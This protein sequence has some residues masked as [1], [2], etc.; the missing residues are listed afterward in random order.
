MTTRNTILCWVQILPMSH[1]WEA[2]MKS[3]SSIALKLKEKIIV[4]REQMPFFLT[5]Y[6]GQV[7]HTTNE[8]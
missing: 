5:K 2:K 7:T 3:Q 1:N 6:F 4:G 8:D